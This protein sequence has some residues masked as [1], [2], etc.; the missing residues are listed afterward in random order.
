MIVTKLSDKFC[1]PSL[2]SLSCQLLEKYALTRSQELETNHWKFQPVSRITHKK[3]SH[4]V[5]HICLFKSSTDY[6]N[7]LIP[8]FGNYMGFCITQIILEALNF[9]VF[10]FSHTFPLLWEFTFSIFWESYGFVPQGKYARNLL[11][12]LYF[13]ILFPYYINSIFPFFG[14][15]CMDFCFTKNI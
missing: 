2:P 7:S 8:C 5:R 3:L 1:S 10:L 4:S 14:N 12:Y 9:G 6:V 15:Y 11:G 13:L